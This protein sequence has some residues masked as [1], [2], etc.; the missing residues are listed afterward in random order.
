MVN[1]MSNVFKKTV[2][3]GGEGFLSMA[4]AIM[5]AVGY[6]LKIVLKMCKIVMQCI[7]ILFEMLKTLISIMKQVLASVKIVLGIVKVVLDM[8]LIVVGVI[9]TVGYHVSV[10]ILKILWITASNILKLIRCIYRKCRN[11]TEIEPDN[12]AT[13]ITPN[14]QICTYD[15]SNLPDEQVNAN[16]MIELL[17]TTRVQAR[18]LHDGGSDGNNQIIV[19]REDRKRI[20]IP[21]GRDV[22]RMLLANHGAYEENSEQRCLAYD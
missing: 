4:V 13:E 3:S 22:Q 11:K 19:N 16:G 18:L 9:I 6:L 7:A 1:E 12:K 2:R 14:S 21:N 8:V 17:Q 20:L 10:A 15:R 5:W